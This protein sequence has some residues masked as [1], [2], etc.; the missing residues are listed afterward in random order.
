MHPHSTNT[1]GRNTTVSLSNDVGLVSTFFPKL[2]LWNDPCYAR[3][4]INFILSLIKS[5]QEL[6]AHLK[7]IVSHLIISLIFQTPPLEPPLQLLPM[8]S[9]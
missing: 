8:G 2:F 7:K 3:K 5:Q 4:Q 9:K 6:P 1:E